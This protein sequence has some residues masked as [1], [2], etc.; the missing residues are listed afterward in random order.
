MTFHKSKGIRIIVY[1]DTNTF[2]DETSKSSMFLG[3]K[4]IVIISL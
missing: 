2:L 4:V 3:K 1:N